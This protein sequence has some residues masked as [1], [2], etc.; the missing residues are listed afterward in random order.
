[1][2][3]ILTNWC[4]LGILA[5]D[6]YKIKEVRVHDCVPSSGPGLGILLQQGGIIESSIVRN[7]DT[8]VITYQNN[9]IWNLVVTGHEFFGLSVRAPVCVPCPPGGGSLTP[10]TGSAVSR[11]VISHPRSTATE[12]LVYDCLDGG[13]QDGSN[14]VDGHQA[15]FNIVGPDEDSVV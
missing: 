7:C 1:I 9:K 6:S 14:S 10:G 12:G 13:C 8:G 11:T 5:G 4:A 2:E 15:G 3:G